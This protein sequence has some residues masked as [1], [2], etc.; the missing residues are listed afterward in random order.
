MTKLEAYRDPDNIVDGQALLLV[1]GA[2]NFAKNHRAIGIVALGWHSYLQSK[3]IPF[4]SLDASK[5]NAWIFRDIQ[6]KALKASKE[7]AELFGE[8]AVMRGYG[9]RN[10]TLMAVA[11]TT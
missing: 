1:E 6:Q 4:D 10:S 2:Y 7:L 5:L 3:M 9:R 8:P 11:P